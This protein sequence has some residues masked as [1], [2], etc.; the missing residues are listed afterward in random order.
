MKITFLVFN[1]TGA[2]GTTRS[3]ISQ[4]TALAE[5][6]A[7]HD[8]R[9]ISVTRVADR[10]AYDVHERVRLDYLVDLRDRKSPR[11]P[12]LTDSSLSAAALHT[13]ESVL[14]PH[15]WDSQFTALTDVAMD[16]ALPK[17]DTDVLVT[18]TPGLMTSAERLVSDRIALVHQEH[19]SSS[20]RVGNLEPLLTGA[21][22]VDVVALLTEANASWLRERLGGIAPRIE[23]V[24]NPL[25]PG[26]VPRS[27]LD[28]PLIVAAGRLVP[29]KQFG[30]LI[31]AF[32]MV[33]DELPE[34]RLRLFGEGRQRAMLLG[35][36]RK[37][38]IYDR[39]ELPS[40]APDMAGEW[41]K[42][43]ISALSSTAEGYP[44]V[45]QEAMAAG[46]P[47]VSYDCPSG[48]REII[49]HGVNGLLVMPGSEAGLAEAFWH[50]AHDHS[51]R[52]RMGGA[53]ADA[54]ELWR[55][56]VVARR[57]EEIFDEA[58]RARRRGGRRV[59]QRHRAPAVLADRSDAAR[60]TDAVTPAQARRQL[61][62]L[63]ATIAGDLG[64]RWWVIPAPRPAL[65]LPA[66][67]RE[68]FFAALAKAAVPEWAS[69]RDPGD[70]GWPE[71]RGPVGDLA[72]ALARVATPRVALEAWPDKADGP[73]IL[74]D[75]AGGGVGVE[76]QF[77]DRG[78]DGTLRA[79]LANG[80]V[81]AVPPH[82]ATT[83]RRIESLDLPTLPI[84]SGARVGE[85]TFD[86]DVVYTWV[87]GG[88]PDWLAALDERRGIS[89]ELSSSSAGRARFESRDELRYSM[90]SVHLFAPWVRR[91]HL[92][93]AGQVPDWL[94]PSDERINLVDHRDILP[95]EVLPTFNSHAIE[96]ALHRIDGLAEHFV[97]FNDDMLLARPLP[98]ERFFDGSGRFAVFTAE[99]LV[100]DP[101]PAGRPAYVTAAL[102]NRS[103]LRDA[104]GK[105][106][107]HHLAHA[108]YPLTVSAV[109]R[110]VEQF[111][112]DIER[113][114]RSPFRTADDVSTLSSLVP[115]HALLTGAAYAD[116]IDSMFVD[117]S[118][119]NVSFQFD[120]LL[121]RERETMCFGDHEDY[122][123]DVREVDRLLADFLA[124]YFPIKAPWEK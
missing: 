71:R 42:A 4:A 32:A 91:I 87:D 119:T 78:R 52:K 61:L 73:T 13:R 26:F 9:I 20:D 18:V 64:A 57:W 10:P 25:P 124:R 60:G 8:V 76:V 65:V 45:M 75:G 23:V 44:L 35:T 100:G 66:T 7:G 104:F 111:G 112:Q 120:K 49:D 36:A 47:V 21:A 29:E 116:R 114:E 79:P 74:S 109:R 5:S 88:D 55:P 117:L 1:V 56:E 17:L 113:T 77:W 58:V 99:H 89:A 84:M 69:L 33:A 92:V 103:L 102:H 82:V 3:V 72:P 83:T 30:H 51:T 22:R 38:G 31:R 28:Q 86:V 62:A 98:A 106:L 2:G 96:T 41:A 37:T 101:A 14:V 53:A 80:Y 40:F 115:H 34:W 90:R 39:F 94:D 15:R 43:S 121:Q 122:A 107:T 105:T 93:T 63:V 118:S 50:L 27:R 46:V 95:A 16:A 85:V 24:P 70:H 97:Y 48:P 59:A 12:H 54:A 123:F 81:D 11:L 110:T 68:S 67:E 108:P 19:R 6:T